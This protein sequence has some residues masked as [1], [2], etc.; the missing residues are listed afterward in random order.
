MRVH[1][2]N[3]FV[4]NQRPQVQKT[5]EQ[6]KRSVVVVQEWKLE[7][8]FGYGGWRLQAHIEVTVE[9]D[10]YEVFHAK[11]ISDTPLM[12]LHE[13][14]ATVEKANTKHLKL[15]FVPDEARIICY[16]DGTL[17]DF[18]ATAVPRR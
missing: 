16:E 1:S 15:E 11:V 13:I 8:R 2:E 6:S 10:A 18:T 17:M 5:L 7:N 3:T 12:T 9:E 14:N 4:K